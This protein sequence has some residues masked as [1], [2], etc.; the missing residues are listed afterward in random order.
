M[1]SNS[2]SLAVGTI[3]AIGMT[4]D[5]LALYKSLVSRLENRGL[6]VTRSTRSSTSST[7][8]SC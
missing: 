7:V 6:E 5:H 4:L 2:V 8:S 1:P 3:L